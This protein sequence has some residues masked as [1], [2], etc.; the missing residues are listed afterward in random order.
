MEE[1]N[2][3]G[4]PE[5]ESNTSRLS[6]PEAVLV[7]LWLLV[8]VFGM[9]FLLVRFFGIRDNVQ[10]NFLTY[11]IGSVYML[12][13]GFPFLRRDFNVLCEHPGRVILQILSCYAAMMLMNLAVSGL[14]SLFV[15]AAENP[16]NEAVM[17]LVRVETNKMN[18][19]AIFFAPFVEEMIFRAG[20]FGTIRRRSRVL[21][22]LVSILLFSVYH[23]WGYAL[24]DPMR[25]LYV[26]QYIPAAYLLCRC[27]ERA[28]CIWASLFFHML[29]NFV[30]LQALNMLEELV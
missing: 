3:P 6:I 4:L 23:V 16:N 1:N 18:T 17:G 7:L 21:A 30:S 15:D 14:L 29:T 12:A 28:D 8:H 24:S 13:V 9:K 11:L 5:R 2:L 26:I 10:I 22:Y 19:I 27:Y 25:W 20:I